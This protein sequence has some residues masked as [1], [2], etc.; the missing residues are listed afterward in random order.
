[1]RGRP[2]RKSHFMTA[3]GAAIDSNSASLP[4]G[5]RSILAISI[6]SP[7]RHVGLSVEPGTIRRSNADIDPRLARPASFSCFGYFNEVAGMNVVDVAVNRNVLS[8]ERMLTDTTHVLSN[9]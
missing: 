5:S 4:S 2:H 7:K 9:A 3:G 1:M 8:D 6:T